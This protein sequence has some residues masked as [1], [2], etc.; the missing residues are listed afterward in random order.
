M[1]A[2]LISKKEP[3]LILNSER[4]TP[5][6]FQFTADDYGPNPNANQSIQKC[7]NNGLI[8][9]VSVLGNFSIPEVDL[10]FLLNQKVE[11]GVHLNCWTGN[12]LLDGSEFKSWQKI[13]CL[14]L[15]RVTETVPFPNRLA[16]IDRLGQ[17]FR[18]QIMNSPVKA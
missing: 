18:K 10:D 8:N 11:C 15:T 5:I 2:K 4:N 12:S 6:T 7:F 13:E 14:K 17:E 3:N 1:N 16:L 9:F